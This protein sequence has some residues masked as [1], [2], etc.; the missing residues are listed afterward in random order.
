[1]DLVRASRRVFHERHDGAGC[2]GAIV[3]WAF[4]VPPRSRISRHVSPDGMR[5]VL[6]LLPHRTESSL[7]ARPMI[8]GS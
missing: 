5:A 3:T 6:A 2:Q 4:T 8:S 1:V 7:I